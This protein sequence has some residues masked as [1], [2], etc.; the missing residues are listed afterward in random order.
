MITSQ[1]AL[2]AIAVIA[3]GLRLAYA[4]ATGELRAPQTWETEQISTNLLEHHE[5]TFRFPDRAVYRAYAEP[6]HPFIGAA[7]YALLMD[8]HGYNSGNM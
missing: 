6:M 3:F 7:V 4:A 8:A 1:R 5:F 2:L